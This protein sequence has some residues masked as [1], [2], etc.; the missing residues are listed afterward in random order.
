M[1]C[2]GGLH[3][4]VLQVR[5]L[6]TSLYVCPYMYVLICT[7]LYVC[8][9][10]YCAPGTLSLRHTQCTHARS[11]IWHTS[12]SK[13]E[14]SC[15][16]MYVLI[17][18]S[19]YVCP[20][21]YRGANWKVCMPLQVS[22]CEVGSLQEAFERLRGPINSPVEILVQVTRLHVRVY[23]CVYVCIC[24]YMYVYV[25][26]MCIYSRN[27]SPGNQVACSCVYVCMCMYYVYVYACIMC[28]YVHALYI[29]MRI[30]CI[31]ICILDT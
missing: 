18:M 21:R 31:Y 27:P 16:Y 9:Y 14:A 10:M 8:P 2:R 30:H 5:S 1:Y 28:M 17:C 13:Q 3:D 26:I 23:M 22:G 4:E 20:Y 29:S 11:H 6:C 7:S 19:L 24:M 25:C 15:R 12:G